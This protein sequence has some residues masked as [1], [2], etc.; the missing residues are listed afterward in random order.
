MQV[1]LDN[2]GYVKSW[3]LDEK[4]GSLSQADALTIATP[5]D[6]DPVKFYREFKSYKIADGKLVK[7]SKRLKTIEKERAE[8]ISQKEKI[9]LTESSYAEKLRTFIEA[10]PVEERSDINTKLYFDLESFTFKWK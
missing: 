4:Q 9:S 6:F 1:L 8:I 3:I 7:D 5:S 2:N 10:I